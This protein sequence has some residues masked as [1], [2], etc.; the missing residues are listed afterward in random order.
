MAGGCRSANSTWFDLIVDAARMLCCL[1]LLE[2]QER[3]NSIDEADTDAGW[4]EPC[5]VIA[6]KIATVRWCAIPLGIVGAFGYREL[7]GVLFFCLF[8]QSLEE[9]GK[10]I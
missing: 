5:S 7:A 10:K 6:R 2:T 8:S 3:R 4:M 9:I 1:R